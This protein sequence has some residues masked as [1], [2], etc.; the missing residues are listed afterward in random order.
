MIAVFKV[1]EH[2]LKYSIKSKNEV[3]RAISLSLW[4]TGI[5]TVHS[6]KESVTEETSC[7]MQYLQVVNT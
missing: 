3:S 4:T 1:E 2:R 5:Q 6:V 7:C